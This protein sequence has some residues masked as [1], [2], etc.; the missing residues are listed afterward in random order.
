MRTAGSS[1][2]REDGFAPRRTKRH[3]GSKGTKNAEGARVQPSNE[4]LAESKPA[5]SEAEPSRRAD[6]LARS[7]SLLRTPWNAGVW[8]NGASSGSTGI[9]QPEN[10]S[11]ALSRSL[12]S[13]AMASSCRPRTA[14]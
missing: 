13:A 10:D 9:V 4:P 2:N 12:W 7:A 3:E 1:N 14:C 6:Y 8:R 11:S 5:L